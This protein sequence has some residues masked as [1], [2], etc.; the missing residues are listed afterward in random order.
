MNYLIEAMQRLEQ[1]KAENAS[2]HIV[3]VHQ[4]TVEL[5]ARLVRIHTLNRAWQ[6]LGANGGGQ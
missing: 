1:A 3:Q 4:H 5:L 6:M 2:F